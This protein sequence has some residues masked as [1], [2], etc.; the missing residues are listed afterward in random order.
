MVVIANARES[1]PISTGAPIHARNVTLAPSADMIM[2]R[3]AAGGATRAELVRDLRPITQPELA[4][5]L[6]RARADADVA[7]LIAL[8]LM[9]EVR[10]RLKATGAGVAHAATVLG[11]D[12]DALSTWPDVRGGALVAQALGFAA[13]DRAL[14]KALANPDSVRSLIVQRAFGLSDSKPMSLSKLRAALAVRALERAFG[15]QIKSGLGSGGGLGPKPSRL[16]AAQLSKTPRDY[17]SD[18]RLIAALAAEDVGAANSETE[19]LKIALLKRAFKQRCDTYA[20]P[21]TAPKP[22]AAK[23][24]TASPAPVAPKAVANDRGTAGQRPLPAA[25]P[26]LPGFVKAVQTAAN[27]RAEG[28]PGNRKAFISHVWQEIKMA[29]PAWAL[30]EIEFKGMLAEAHRLGGLILAN[31]DLKDK[32]HIQEFENSAIQYKNTVW[33]FVRV[34]EA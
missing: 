1:T 17:G 32:K 15:N 4:P 11:V 23:T 33:H 26:D 16:L 34:E 2:V 22:V 12:P 18:G 24:H 19:T 14:I 27:R 30:S 25:R 28:W 13:G 29:H 8:G 20:T 7:E 5:A 21:Q 6:W 9:A 10:A 31:A 3:V